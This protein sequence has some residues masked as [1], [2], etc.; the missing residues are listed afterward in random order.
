MSPEAS[1][2]PPKRLWLCGTPPYALSTHFWRSG[3][4]A[5]RPTGGEARARAPASAKVASGH[6]QAYILAINPAIIADSGGTCHPCS[7]YKDGEP[8]SSCFPDQITPF[9]LP[10]IFT[11]AYVEQPVLKVASHEG[12]V[13]RNA[14]NTP[15][16]LRTR[17]F[18]LLSGG[19][20]HSDRS[21]LE[22]YGTVAEVADPTRSRT[23]LRSSARKTCG[24]TWSS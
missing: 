19:G 17:P 4:A 3:H 10:A 13:P 14:R 7:D 16:G 2:R 5:Q 20:S 24:G 8:P 23:T 21:G 15:L 18:G 22:S 1:S 6:I 9:Y 12:A 11:D